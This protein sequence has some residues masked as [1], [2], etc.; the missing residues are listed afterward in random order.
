MERITYSQQKIWPNDYM[1][2]LA[3][4][5]LIVCGFLSDPSLA[6]TDGAALAQNIYDRPDGDDAASKAVMILTKKGSKPRQR[7]LY[8]YRLDTP[9]GET[10]SLTRFTEPADIS[11]TGLLS[12]DRPG[13]ENSQWIYLPA[14]DRA[15]R[16]SASRKGGRFVGSDIFYEDMSKRDVSKDR[17]RMLGELPDDVPFRDDAGDLAVAIRHHD[18]A[19]PELRE[20]GG[21]VAEG[22]ALGNRLDEILRLDFEKLLYEH[23]CGPFRE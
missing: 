13:D 17:H 15:R 9:D 6:E 2:Y 3:P 12:H 16:I 8:T 1:K 23:E 14:L 5:L 22:L 4:A 10:L 7:T 11:G 21:D 20:A 18:R 19:N